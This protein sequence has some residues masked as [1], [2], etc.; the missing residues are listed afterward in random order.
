M[1]KSQLKEN[2]YKK[3]SPFLKTLQKKYLTLCSHCAIW[4]INLILIFLFL[5][6]FA[7]V[8][9]SLFPDETASQKLLKTNKSHLDQIYPGK[10]ADEVTQIL[11]E[12]WTRNFMYEPFTGFKEAPYN[13]RFVNISSNGFRLTQNQGPWPPKPDQITVYLFGG[14]TTFNYGTADN[15]TIASYLQTELTNKNSKTPIF[16]YNFGRAFYYSTQERIL[17][18]KML[19]DGNIPNIAIFIDGL[20]DFVYPK[21]EPAYA[22][23]FQKYFS[24]EL[25]STKFLASELVIRLPFVKLLQQQVLPLLKPSNNTPGN[26]SLKKDD[27]MIEKVIMRYIQNKKMIESISRENKISSI[28]V[29]QPIPVYKQNLR[30]P[31]IDEDSFRNINTAKYGY[32]RLS[33]IKK[34][35]VFGD[36]FVWLADIQEQYDGEIYV[37]KVHYSAEF[38]KEI[39][40]QIA[41]FLRMKK[42]II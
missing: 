31:K 4:F 26:L 40:K 25:T 13:G 17:Y 2:I 7:I 41:N 37:D 5:N 15:E 39:A 16:I 33:Q 8:F 27:E 14:S 22:E 19:V 23:V 42:I 34:N 21:N 9:L 12:S 30:L 35:V 6:L 3:K 11:K 29:I 36:N 24:G 28:F 10:K 38:S 32:E 20:N 18:E 1:E